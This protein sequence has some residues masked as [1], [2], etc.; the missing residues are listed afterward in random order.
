MMEGWVYWSCNAETWVQFPAV[1][2]NFFVL[3]YSKFTS[4]K[5]YMIL[6]ELACCSFQNENKQTN[7]LKECLLK[8]KHA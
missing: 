6:S 4:L 2:D 3:Q 8:R 1:S 7:A 5:G